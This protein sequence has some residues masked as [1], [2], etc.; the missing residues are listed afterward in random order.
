MASRRRRINPLQARL[1]QSPSHRSRFPIVTIASDRAISKDDR[2]GG[3]TLGTRSSSV[4]GC[5]I[6]GADESGAFRPLRHW[7]RNRREDQKP[8][9]RPQC[10]RTWG[11]QATSL[12]LLELPPCSIIPIHDL[13]PRSEIAEPGPPVRLPGEI[14]QDRKRCSIFRAA[15][16]WI[17]PRSNQGQD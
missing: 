11:T 6:F 5:P 17:S 10:G 16:G 9:V 7:E 15:R 1:Y 8:H 3:P 4:V 14:N 13:P 2:P 12:A